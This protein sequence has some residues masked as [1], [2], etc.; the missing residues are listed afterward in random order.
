MIARISIIEIH[1]GEPVS[2]SVVQAPEETAK[3]LHKILNGVV[4]KTT[5]EGLTELAVTA[6]RRIS[7]TPTYEEIDL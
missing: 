5:D 2:T 3:K 6:E 1:N 7:S 4:S